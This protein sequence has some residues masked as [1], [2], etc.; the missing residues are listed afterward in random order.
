[1][2]IT[3]ASLSPLTLT[4]MQLVEVIFRAAARLNVPAQWVP[5]RI[6]DSNFA[7]EEPPTRASPWVGVLLA[8]LQTFRQ[9]LGSMAALTPEDVG[10]V[11]P[12]LRTAFSLPCAQ[13]GGLACA[14]VELC[15]L[16]QHKQCSTHCLRC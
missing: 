7:L 6:A 12:V 13:P 15:C 2:W 3:A 4:C 14:D 8:H 11:S 1:M 10:V 9:R 16:Q 5:D